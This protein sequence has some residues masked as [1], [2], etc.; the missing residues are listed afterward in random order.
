[1]EPDTVEPAVHRR[2]VPRDRV[3]VHAVWEVLLAAAVVVAVLA[4]QREDSTAL[5]GDGLRD[6]LV[7]LAAAVLLGSGFALS[8]RA[9]VPNL[10][11]GAVAVLA[12]VLTAWL[13]DQHGYELR[14]AVLITL[15]A[16]IALGIA[17]AIVVVGFRLP[18][19]A[20]GLGAALGLYAAVLSLSAG[21]AMLLEGGPD[22]RR[23]AWP[24]A[25]GAVAISVAGGALGLTPRVRASLGGYRPAGDA[26]S[27]RGRRAATMAAVA[28]VGSTLLAAGAGLIIALRLRAV[29]PD[30]G[31]M[32]LGQAAAVALLGGT[33][34]Y[35]RRGGLFGTVLAAGFLQLAALWLGLVE[36]QPWTRP[37]LL[38]GAILLG[39]LVGRLVEAAGSTR[40][41]SEQYADEDDGGPDTQ[42]WDPYSTGSFAPGADPY[43]TGSF[44]PAASYR[45]D[46]GPVW[47]GQAP[48]PGAEPGREPAPDSGAD[49]YQSGREPG[50][51]RGSGR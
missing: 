17:L 5:S 39:L 31:L 20:V 11:V 46:A 13:R 10:A 16:A 4:V 23:W 50:P 1:M 37:A 26:A 48:A 22:L 51:F 14:I 27:G 49:Q 34:A 25:A 7:L 28:L 18:A 38:G 12:G 42:L 8:L 19:W 45:P 21:R 40:P 30:D 9:A 47:P 15:G 2:P 44:T 41:P 36:A 32:L 6:L 29:V 43:P 3:W 33:S 24:L 35:G